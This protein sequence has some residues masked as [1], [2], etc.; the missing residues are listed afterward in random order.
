MLVKVHLLFWSQQGKTWGC[1]LLLL[2]L[3][4]GFSSSIM[5]LKIKT[6]KIITHRQGF[7]FT[8][9]DNR[10]NQAGPEV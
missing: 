6:T 9:A 8:D 3:L 7:Q 4:L 2:L 1:L 10:H 5:I